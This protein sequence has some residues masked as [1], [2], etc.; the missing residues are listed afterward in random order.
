LTELNEFGTNAFNEDDDED[1]SGNVD[2]EILFGDLET[3]CCIIVV[4]HALNSE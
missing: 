2:E 1:D 3:F 4:S